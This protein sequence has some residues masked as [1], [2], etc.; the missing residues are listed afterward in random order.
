MHFSGSEPP[1]HFSSRHHAQP[2]AKQR[3]YGMR[4]TTPAGQQEY[5]FLLVDPLKEKA[6]QRAIKGAVSFK[7][8]EYGTVVGQGLGEPSQQ[9]KD[10]IC[11]AYDVIFN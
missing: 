1:T 4:Y 10:R 3:V 9:L 7:L 11:A 6:F 8:E 5:Y 2:T